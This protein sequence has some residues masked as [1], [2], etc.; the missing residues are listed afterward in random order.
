MCLRINKVKYTATNKLNRYW[1]Y[2]IGVLSVVVV[3]ESAYKSS[4]DVV[5]C[6]KHQTRFCLNLILNGIFLR[7]SEYGRSRTRLQKY[8]HA[9]SSNNN[10]YLLD[11]DDND[12]DDEQKEIAVYI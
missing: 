6:F 1:S 12:D 11:C 5:Q 8:A 2:S 9:K 3:L 4:V 10:K 7:P